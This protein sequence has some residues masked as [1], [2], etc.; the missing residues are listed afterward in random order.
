MSPKYIHMYSY[1]KKRQ[2]NIGQTHS[3]EKATS[4]RSKQRCT[5]NARKSKQPPEARR[6]KE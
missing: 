3:V 2:M 5:K 6:G 4:K 1:L